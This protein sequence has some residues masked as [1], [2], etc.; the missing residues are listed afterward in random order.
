[1]NSGKSLD[2]AQSYSSKWDNGCKTTIHYL[3]RSILIHIVVLLVFSHMF[4]M[5]SMKD[6]SLA[7]KGICTVA[8]KDKPSM[9][10]GFLSTVIF[11]FCARNFAAPQDKS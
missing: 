1:M 6:R 3:Y 11:H 9:L 2:F 5:N 8:E 10:A 7:N 4:G